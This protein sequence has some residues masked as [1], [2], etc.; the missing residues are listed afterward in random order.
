MREGEIAEQVV[1]I[2][3]LEAT[4]QQLKSDERQQCIERK[5]QWNKAEN[6]SRKM[7]MMAEHNAKIQVQLEELGKDFK[8]LRED[9]NDVGQAIRSVKGY[10]SN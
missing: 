7:E 8:Q 2:A 9:Q 1:R 6:Q 4:I 3:D 10:K 5:Y